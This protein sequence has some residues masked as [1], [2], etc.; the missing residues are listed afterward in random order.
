MLTIKISFARTSFETVWKQVDFNLQLLIF[1]FLYSGSFLN[2]YQTNIGDLFIFNN[3][4]GTGTR[5]GSGAYGKATVPVLIVNYMIPD[6]A[7]QHC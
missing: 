6:P 5:V 3:G 1:F 4:A 7:P 2:L